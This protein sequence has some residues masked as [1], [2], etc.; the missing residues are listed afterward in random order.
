MRREGWCGRVK[1]YRGGVT[2]LPSGPQSSTFGISSC[3][4]IEVCAQETRWDQSEVGGVG[5]GAE[6]RDAQHQLH[7]VSR[8]FA[9]WFS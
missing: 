7:V 3:S 2:A 6:P 1:G 5:V 9:V 4:S 8:W